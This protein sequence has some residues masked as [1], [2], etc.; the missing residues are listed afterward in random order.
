MALGACRFRRVRVEGLSLYLTF[1]ETQAY[2]TPRYDQGNNKRRLQESII[3]LAR[4]LSELLSSD[5]SRRCS[6]KVINWDEVTQ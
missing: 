1:L 4:T 5:H 6:R 3:Y 2:K